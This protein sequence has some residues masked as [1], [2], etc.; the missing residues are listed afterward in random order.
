MAADVQS[1]IAAVDDALLNSARMC[2]S[3]LEATRGTKIPA[4]QTQRLL[5]S[6]TAG[7]STVVSGR[8]EIVSAIRTMTAIQ[9]NSNLRET[10]FGCPLDWEELKLSCEPAQPTSEPQLA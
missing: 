9:A 8:A 3:I 5:R 4:T 10:A 7:L 1:A 2:V 6:V